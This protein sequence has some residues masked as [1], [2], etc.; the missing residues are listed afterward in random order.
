MMI[1]TR[2]KAKL[3]KTLSYPVGAEAIS[4]ALGNAPHASNLRLHFFDAAVWPASEFQRLLREAMPYKLFVV[5]YQPAF[6]ANYGGAN[7]LVEQGY[8]DKQWELQ[9][10]PVLRHLRQRAGQLLKEQ[11]FPAMVE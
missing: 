7:D 4:K 6:K 2:F 3:P 1:P 5:A 8:Y 9:V 10:Y 11:G